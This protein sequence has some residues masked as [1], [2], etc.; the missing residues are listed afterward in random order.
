MKGLTTMFGAL[1]LVSGF[2]HAN[3]VQCTLDEMVRTVQVVED[4]PGRAVPCH[5]KYEKV[6]EGVT[7]V[8]W[9]AQ[10][11]GTY[12]RDRAAF[13]VVRLESDGWNC[14][15]TATGRRSLIGAREMQ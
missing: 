10:H 7:E 6:T 11:D 9:R 13:L 8:P 4:N 12:C 14:N 3:A 5:V 2:A 1:L 15:A